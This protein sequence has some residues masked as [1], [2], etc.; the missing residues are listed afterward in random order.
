[1]YMSL[2]VGM[3]VGMLLAGRRN[4]SG[5]QYE[6]ARKQIKISNCIG[7]ISNVC[8]YLAFLLPS[9]ESNVITNVGR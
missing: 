6:N 9:I 2:L 3:P 7:K 4:R 5:K 1:M 8:F